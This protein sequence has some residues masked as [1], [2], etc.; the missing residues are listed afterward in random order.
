M[1]DLY[2]RWNQSVHESRMLI[3]SNPFLIIKSFFFLMVFFFCHLLSRTRQRG[4]SHS[5]ILICFSVI[6]LFDTIFIPQLGINRS[7]RPQFT[8]RPDGN[9]QSFTKPVESRACNSSCRGSFSYCLNCSTIG[10]RPRRTVKLCCAAIANLPWR[11][12][13]FKIYFLGCWI[14]KSFRALRSWTCTR[15]I[16]TSYWFARHWWWFNTNCCFSRYTS[17]STRAEKDH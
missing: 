5:L 16:S 3:F 6:C 12:S 15:F 10:I 8:Q 13:R 1:S 11:S 2:T 14:A 7:S 9:A 17:H 4:N